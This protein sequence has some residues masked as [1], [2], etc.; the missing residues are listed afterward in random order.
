MNA[1][2]QVPS[3]VFTVTS[4]STT[5]SVA[6]KDWPVAATSPAATERAMKSRRDTFAARAFSG[7]WL[8]VV[9]FLAFGL[10]LPIMSHWRAICGV[11]A[12]AGIPSTVRAELVAALAYAR[13]T[14]AMKQRIE[15]L[16]YEPIYDDPLEFAAAIRSE[17]EKYSGIVKR[18]RTAADHRSRAADR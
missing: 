3:G 16:N 9:I 17:T 13:Q 8:S 2:S 7:S 4:L 11:V 15:A 18:T 6:A 5:A 1:A 14:P 10:Q 12:P